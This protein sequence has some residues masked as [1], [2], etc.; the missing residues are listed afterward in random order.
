MAHTTTLTRLTCAAAVAVAAFSSPVAAAEPELV[1]TVIVSR[2]G[3]RSPIA[4]SLQLTDV[5]ANPWP[6][7]P[8]QHPGDL[9]DH[10]AELAKRLG[11]YY[12]ALYATHGL[13]PAQG[14]PPQRAVVAWADQSERTKLSAQSLLEG[15]FPG[16][17]LKYG[18]REGETIDPLFHPTLAGVCSI[19]LARARRDVMRR[20]GGSVALLQRKFRTEFS[21]MQSVLK[22]CS[23]TLCRAPRAPVCTLTELPS[24]VAPGRKGGIWLHGPLAI[25][26]TAAEVFLLEY[27]QGFPLDQVAWGRVSTPQAMRPLL[28]LHTLEFDLLERTPYLATRQGSALVN[29]IV[30]TLQQSIGSGAA[31]APKM[32][33]LVGH[34]TNLFNIGGVLGLHWSLPSYVPD[35]T[36]PAGALH[37]QLWR[38][39][40]SNAYSVKVVYIAQTLDQMRQGTVLDG[41]NPP[42]QASVTIRGCR[43]TG[44]GCPWPTFARLVGRS[45]DRACVGPRQP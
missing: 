21:A 1:S 32:T 15:M 45:V 31:S 10:G 3:V 39:R 22:C 37:F 33:L 23:P 30:T 17:N 4:T 14:C 29:R 40:Q 35:Q 24:D 5:A 6:V 2:H 20:A 43:M 26:S 41:G 44:G 42:E 12:R 8:V 11:V 28:R 13:F 38:D 36:P 16:C 25:A 9:T 7:W 19:D 34:D 18:Y 27:A